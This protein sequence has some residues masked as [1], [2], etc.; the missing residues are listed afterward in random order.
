MRAVSGDA[1]IILGMDTTARLLA[2]L[3]PSAQVHI[4]NVAANLQLAADLGYGDVALLVPTGGSLVVVADARPTTAAAAI[5]VT[6]AGQ[7]LPY[8][9]EPEAYDSLAGGTLV[10]GAHR[11]T[12]RGIAF[13]ST[14]YPVGPS[15]RP[16]AVIVRHLGQSVAEAPG[17]MEVAFM[18]LADRVLDRLRAGPIGDL[19]LDEPYATTRT[20]GDGVLEVSLEG[21]VVY[22][23]PNAV[24]IMR[25][26]GME[27]TPLGGPASALPG[28]ATAVA[29]VLGTDSGRS[30]TVEVAGRV[31]AYRTIGLVDGALVL[32]EDVTDARRREQELR[33]KEAT[34]REVHHRVKNNLQ[35]IASLLR[36][37]A[38]RSESD[39]AARA[40]AEAVERVSSMAVVHEM[41]AESADE[42][43]DL[44]SAVRTVVDMVRRGLAG[45]ESGVVVVVTGETGLVPAQAATS[46]ALVAAELV[47]NAIEH[48]IG[49]HGSGSVRVTMRRVGDDVVL[50]VRDDGHGLPDGFSVESFA[51]LGLAIVRTVVED[52]LRGTLAF[53]GR[54][55]TTVTVRV[56]VSERME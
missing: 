5:P 24:N 36:I 20:A 39:E 8:G 47:H 28:G 49:E 54:R 33:V 22:A 11:R 48:G 16:Y 19:D 46:L 7:V 32:V 14:A 53:G 29:P 40:L 45:A 4:G 38:R 41:L 15:D 51:N 3:E 44:A 30:S 31:L 18:R 56:P 26:A 37:Q 9:E 2:A 34:I 6:R 42:S 12:K 23:S 17:K 25:A 13:T 50:E 10:C 21:T 35:T 1:A 52:D 27:G 55:G 43:V